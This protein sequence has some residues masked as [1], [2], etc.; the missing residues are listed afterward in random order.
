MAQ[1]TFWPFPPFAKSAGRTPDNHIVAPEID[2]TSDDRFPE[3]A[4]HDHFAVRCT[5]FLKIQTPGTYDLYTASDDGS[6][7]YVDGES[8]PVLTA[9]CTLLTCDPINE[10][11]TPYT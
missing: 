10:T 5:G 1:P 9:G 8:R 2:F 3:V 6:F 4:Q 11:H 7:L